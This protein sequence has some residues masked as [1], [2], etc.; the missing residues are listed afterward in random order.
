MKIY[1]SSVAI[2]LGS[3]LIIWLCAYQ[4]AHAVRITDES[5]KEVGGA[6]N[7]VTGQNRFGNDEESVRQETADDANESSALIGQNANVGPSNNKQHDACTTFSCY[8]ASFFNA[9]WSLITTILNAIW[10]F[11]VTIL[12]VVFWI[13]VAIIAL[14]A[15][16]SG[17]G[18]SSS[19]RSSSNS[20][21]DSYVPSDSYMQSGIYHRDRTVWGGHAD[22]L[23]HER[24]A[25]NVTRVIDKHAKFLGYCRDGKT[26][27][28]NCKIVAQSEEPGLL[29]KGYDEKHK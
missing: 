4:S 24:K 18:S 16:G 6:P 12:T 26:F 7:S 1:R 19:D 22:I 13:I 27:D 15:L 2:V 17:Q 21:R 20:S 9:V 8:V 23:Y 25:G 28:K 3:F 14:C 10:N 29:F 11:I 5:T